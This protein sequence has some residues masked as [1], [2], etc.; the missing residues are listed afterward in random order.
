MNEIGEILKEARI[1]KGYTLDDLQQITKIQKR[2]LQAIEDGKT[3]ILPGRFYARAF[4]KQYADIVGLDGEKL[5]NEN[6]DQTTQEA[7]EEFAESV[8][9]APTRSTPSKRSGFLSDFSEYL[10]TILIFLLVAAILLVIYF[11][12]RETDTPGENGNALIN[13]QNTE[14]VES[15]VTDESN[16]EAETADEPDETGDSA[17]NEA[18]NNEDENTDEEETT[19]EPDE[20][21]T[22]I[23]NSTGATTTYEISGTHPDEQTLELSATGGDSWVSITVDGS[24]VEAGLISSGSTLDTTFGSDVSQVD[25]VIGNAPVTEINLNGTALEY[26]PEAAN[27]V[28]QDIVLEFIE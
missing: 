7:S 17:A 23:T 22:E 11:A 8:N 10:P 6:T 27:T 15:P 21:T 2:Y 3:E 4:I 26:A 24:T 28:R 14:Q 25:I 16:E 19:E 9:V 20:Q 1:E 5:L 13:E 18:E 12:W